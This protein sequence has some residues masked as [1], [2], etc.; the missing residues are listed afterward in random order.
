MNGLWAST[1]YNGLNVRFSF[2]RIVNGVRNNPTSAHVIQYIDEQNIGR[3]ND[4]VFIEGSNDEVFFDLPVIGDCLV[5]LNT[6]E[7]KFFEFDPERENDS[8]SNTGGV[9][10]ALPN[11][12]MLNLTTPLFEDTGAYGIPYIPN[13]DICVNLYDKD[14]NRLKPQR[15]YFWEVKDEGMTYR[16]LGMK[17]VV[18][19]TSVWFSLYM[20]VYDIDGNLKDAYDVVKYF[21]IECRN[22][23][24]ANKVLATLNDGLYRK[25][26]GGPVG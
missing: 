2:E 20:R 15:P 21:G 16:S 11:Q 1:Y 5:I 26:Y 24:F 10:D 18:I 13:R 12:R 17:S 9:S 4:V 23:P 14:G 6:G 19:T 3:E 22:N 25:E 7:K 8:D